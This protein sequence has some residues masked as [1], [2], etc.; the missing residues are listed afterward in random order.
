MLWILEIF[1]RREAQF[2][3]YFRFYVYIWMCVIILIVEK[4]KIK[5]K[6]EFLFKLFIDKKNIF[7][8]KIQSNLD[9]TQSFDWTPWI[10]GD[11]YLDSK[12]FPHL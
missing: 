9:I 7:L 8:Q 12:A 5:I 4:N 11:L 1:I 3:G 6:K 10:S 2:Y